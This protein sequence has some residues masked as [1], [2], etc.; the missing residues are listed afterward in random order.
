M[1]FQPIIVQ[2][3]RVL[4]NLATLDEVLK[5]LD[6]SVKPYNKHAIQ[7]DSNS[8]GVNDTTKLSKLTSQKIIDMNVC[9]IFD[10]EKLTEEAQNSIL[11]TLEEPNKNLLIVLLTSNPDRLLET[12]RSRC[13]EMFI[14]RGTT[15][16]EELDTKLNLFKE[17]IEGNFLERKNVIE[18]IMREENPREVAMELILYIMKELGDK[19]L[20]RNIEE[21]KKIYTGIGQGVNLK[22]SLSNLNILFE[23]N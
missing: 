17:F 22:L 7:S 11:K 19:S 6:L 5:I 14:G 3:D 15:L 2:K 18:I 4:D 10:S 20:I 1:F 12:I 16:D 9:A 8:I 13:L 21:I 23:F